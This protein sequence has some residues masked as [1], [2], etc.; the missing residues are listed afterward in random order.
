M[1][2]EKITVSVDLLYISYLTFNRVLKS[3]FKHTSENARMRNLVMYA[4]C[5]YQFILLVVTFIG[6]YTL[7]FSYFI[8]PVIAIVFL[9]N[10]RARFL[11]IF[12]FL[13][14]TSVVL[15]A[16]FS[17]VLFSSI[18][19]YIMFKSTFQ[20]SSIFPT[21]GDTYYQLLTLLTT[22][23]FPDVML[24]AYNVYYL[25]AWFFVVYFTVA[26]YF[27][28]N[29]L[30]ANVFNMFRIRLEAKAS[31]RIQARIHMIAKYLN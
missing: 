1:L 28:L 31:T 15:L 14:D 26:F 7:P 27:L 25:Y 17:Y 8:R 13:K 16:I 24:P 12:T 19:F 6:Y 10:V 18:L 9:S 29:I 21:L 4:A 23:N 5:V 3:R 30:L 2:N 22:A 11:D 20:G